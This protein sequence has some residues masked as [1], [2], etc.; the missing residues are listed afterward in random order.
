MDMIGL[1]T[2]DTRQMAVY[3]PNLNLP[4]LP[5]HAEPSLKMGGQTF[6][7]ARYQCLVIRKLCLQEQQSMV[8]TVSPAGRSHSPQGAS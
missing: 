5:G 8:T 2:V 3:L 1:T 6:G 4:C 7:R